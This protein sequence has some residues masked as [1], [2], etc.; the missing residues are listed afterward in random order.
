MN[1]GRFRKVFSKRLGMLVAVEETAKSQ[2][3][4]PGDGDGAG[5]PV[6]RSGVVAMLTSVS[7]ALLLSDPGTVLA[8]S[9]PTGG[10]VVGGQIGISESGN[11]MTINQGTQRGAINWNT[12]NVGSGNTVQFN[13]PGSTSQT[14]NRVV[15]GVPSNIQ[16]QLLANGQVLIQNAN[17]ILFGSGAVVN[18]GSL[19]ATTK[20]IDANQFMAGGALNLG[21]TGTSAGIVNNGT[22]NAQGYVT[23]IGDQV[24]NSGTISTPNGKVVLAAGDSATV[25]LDNGQGISVT[26]NNA[27]ANALVDNSGNI[28][29]GNGAVL[30]TARGADTVLQT[31]INMS[32]V[33]KAGTVVADAGNTGDAIVTGRIDASN[34]TPGGVGGTVVVT[35]DRVG[36]LGNASINVSGDGQGGT[37]ILGGD[38]LGHVPNSSAASLIQDVNFANLTVVG[39]GAT[40]D[41]GSAHGDGGFVETSGHDLDAQGSIT[42]SAPNGHAGQWLIDPTDVTIST[43]ADANYTGNLGDGTFSGGTSTTATVNA[44]TISNTLSSGT[45]V[46]ITTASSGTATGNITQQAGADIVDSC[47]SE[48][49]LTMLANGSINLSGNIA[50]TGGALDLNLTADIG[51]NGTGSVSTAATSTINLNGG[52]LNVWGNTTGTTT[53]VNLSGVLSNIGGGSITGSASANTGVYIGGALNFS[54][55][56][57]LNITGTTN[58]GAGYGVYMGG[59]LNV[60][61]GNVRVNGTSGGTGV[62]VNVNAPLNVSGGNLTIAGTSTQTTGAVNAVNLSGVVSVT[63]N[64]A[65]NVTGVSYGATG[66]GIYENAAVSVSGGGMTLNGTSGQGCTTAAGN[67]VCLSGN[68]ALTGNGV[69]NITGTALG[70]GL[71]TGVYVNGNLSVTDGAATISGT[72]NGSGQGACVSGCVAVNGTGNLGIAGVSASGGGV[73]IS[74][75]NTTASD[76]G[77]LNITGSSNTGMGVQ[78]TGNNVMA[79]GNGT[80]NIS[81]VSNTT[82]ANVGVNVSNVNLT[83]SV[84][85]DV[86]LMEKGKPVSANVTFDNNGMEAT[87]RMRAGV[88]VSANNYFGLGESYAFSIYGT[89]KR[90]WTGSLAGSVPIFS[91]G[92]RLAGGFTRQQYAVFAGGTNLAGVAN[93]VSA[94]FLYPFTRGLDRNV[95]GGLSLLHTNTSFELTDFHVG[96]HSTLDSVQLSLTANNGDRAQQ[97]RTNVWGAQGALTIGHQRNDDPTDVGPRRAGTYLKLGGSAYGTYALDRSGDLFLSGRLAAQV[98]DRNLDASEQ[99]TLGGPTAVRAYRADEPAADEGVVANVGLYRRFSVATGHQIQPGVFVD[100]AVGRMNHSPWPGW[101]SGYVGVPNVKNVRQLAGYGASIDWLTPFGA[102]VSASVAKPFGFSN[103]SWVE[104]GRKPVQFWVGAT[105][106]H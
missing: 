60:S 7:L 1:K 20:N 50:S 75:V 25:A 92:L 66:I 45:N 82:G 96:T 84:K 58:T 83:N 105:W 16:G 90:M 99:L 54:A 77:T 41:A 89:D 37:V 5:S 97:L 81:G 94:G 36:I 14:L 62:G 106:N 78:L 21:S 68:V 8:Q 71:G 44:S 72:A 56:G 35:G 42:A 88:G 12:F 76:N 38:S 27:T 100:Y 46:T 34:T 47:T 6:V 73:C 48:T 101:V 61:G 102:T 32:G 49:S 53:A 13:Q 18:V 98:S 33:V 17:G 10:Q 85:V 3:K 69:L 28:Q 59:Q 64:G 40:I 57:T 95:W 74:G 103:N 29:T 43:G 23:L 9:L 80:V 26:L 93:T 79:S 19:L 91:D 55:P 65:L 22:I 2:G 104:P 24:K 4:Q 70:T 86:S 30:L 52:V 87:G 39:A 11:T 63:G 31:V 15:G 67:A 51:N